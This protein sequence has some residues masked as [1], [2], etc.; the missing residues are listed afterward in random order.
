MDKFYFNPETLQYKKVE[1]T[2]KH[3]LY[4]FLLFMVLVVL[5]FMGLLRFNDRYL[6][7]PKLNRFLA[8]QQ[9]LSYEL[10]LLNKDIYR[11]ETILENIAFSDD[12]IYRVFFEVDPWPTTL[13]N[14]GVGG[15]YK[16][17]ELKNNKFS[18]LLIRTY[19]NM[20]NLSPK[21]V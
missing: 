13:R 5:L 21:L 4:R 20:D 2:G 8:E 18:D 19:V 14:A 3:R 1:I 11:Y 12:Y 6:A 9:Q 10:N 15:S 7:T 16:Y 17:Q